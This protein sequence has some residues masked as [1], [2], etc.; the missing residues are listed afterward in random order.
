MITLVG[1]GFLGSIFATEFAKLQFAGKIPDDW[2]LIDDDEVDG[3]NPANQNFMLTDVGR[4][5]IEVVGGDLHHMEVWSKGFMVRLTSENMQ[6]LLEGSRLIV[7]AVDN[8]ET[9]QLLWSAAHLLKVP[10]LH[11]G[12]SESGEGRV[13]WTHP[14]YD[15]FSLSPVKTAGKAVKDP[16]SG[17]QPPCELV[18]M[19]AAG[20]QTAYAGATAASIYFGFD[21]W[22]H[23]EGI[24]SSGYL[25]NWL[26]TAD[27]VTP[28]RESWHRV[29]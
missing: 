2:R 8:L 27:T 22:A 29:G 3:R 6:Q 10:V 25:T 14:E 26:C 9:R 1:C 24:P 18:R 12:L 23:L 5:K 28:I 4:P 13:E 11:V 20:W 7:D 15:S 21:P 16:A 19:R 17:Q